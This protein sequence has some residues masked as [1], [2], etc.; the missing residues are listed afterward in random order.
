M[1]DREKIEI[2]IPK[3]CLENKNMLLWWIIRLARKLVMNSNTPGKLLEFGD[4]TP[5]STLEIRN[6]FW[7][8]KQKFS[9]HFKAF[10]IF[11]KKEYWKEITPLISWTN[12]ADIYTKWVVREFLAYMNRNGTKFRINL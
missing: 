9:Y 6:L 3:I 7:I 10:K 1:S 12:W 11:I 8:D 2:E 5:M 4:E